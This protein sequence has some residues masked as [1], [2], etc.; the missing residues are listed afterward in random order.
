MLPEPPADVSAL[1]EVYVVL[2]VTA[3]SNQYTQKVQ[4]VT[5]VLDERGPPTARAREKTLK[6]KQKNPFPV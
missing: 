3:R 1:Y 5:Q 4:I 6:T 2:I